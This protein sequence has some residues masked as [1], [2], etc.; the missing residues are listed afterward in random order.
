MH[1]QR[2]AGLNPPIRFK[3]RDSNPDGAIC[4]NAVFFYNYQ[5]DITYG[6]TCHL[7]K[8]GPGFSR[9]DN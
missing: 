8:P 3:I 7:E 5:Q 4:Y 6:P 9:S 1:T 2:S